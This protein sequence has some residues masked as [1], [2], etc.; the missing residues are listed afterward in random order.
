MKCAGRRGPRRWLPLAAVPVPVLSGLAAGCSGSPPPSRTAA[1]QLKSSVHN[2][3]NVNV[4][5]NGLSWLQTAATAVLSHRS[6]R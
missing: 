5:K 1:S 3:G 6:P 4:A 2:P